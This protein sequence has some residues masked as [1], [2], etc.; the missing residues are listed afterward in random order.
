MKVKVHLLG[1][2]RHFHQGQETLELEL[3]PETPMR[4]VYAKLSVPPGEVMQA[5]VDGLAR[6]P[7]DPVGQCSVIE[8][9]PVLAGG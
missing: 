8:I 3:D 5:L 2:L 1:G 7:D 4:E 6:K 9:F